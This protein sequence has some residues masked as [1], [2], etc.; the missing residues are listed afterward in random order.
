VFIVCAYG[1]DLLYVLCAAER[2]GLLDGNHVFIAIDYAFMTTNEPEGDPC[3]LV[4][5]RQGKYTALVV[6]FSLTVT[7]TSNASLIMIV[8]G[9][10]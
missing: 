5:V 6:S 10:L 8:I 7:G 9:V 4:K 2:I 1:L 3:D